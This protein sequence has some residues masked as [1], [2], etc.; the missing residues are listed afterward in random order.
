MKKFPGG[1]VI[2]VMAAL[3]AGTVHAQE[4]CGAFP[5]GEKTHACACTPDAA[6]GPVWGSGPYTAD[7]DMCTAAYHAGVIGPDGGE[8][9]AR[10]AGS[11][12]AFV[13]SEA[14]GVISSDWGPYPES[15]VFEGFVAAA[16]EEGLE[17]C[18]VIPEEY[19]IYRCSCAGAAMAGGAVWGS[20]PYTAD[21]NICM[22]ALHAGMIGAEG[23]VVLVARSAGL[24]SYPGSEAN[25]VTTNDWGAYGE[26]IVFE[27]P[28]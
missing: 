21:S 26:S 16:A 7:S 13:G 12:D 17:L 4:L 6:V 1:A 27:V 5:A 28:Q 23:G 25:G 10:S 20:W 9:L 15:F 14:N 22:A 2:G 8:V 24:E 11:R 3:G 19:Q 18:G